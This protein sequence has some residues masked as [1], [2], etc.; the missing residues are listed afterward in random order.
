MFSFTRS[1]SQLRINIPGAGAAPKQFGSETLPL[2]FCTGIDYRRYLIS[3][4]PGNFL[5]ILGK[6]CGNS[7]EY[8]I[9]ATMAD[10][11]NVYKIRKDYQFKV[12]C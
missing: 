1:Q 5:L 2:I 10:Y 12:L 4:V 3:T 11:R 6:C 8:Y 7:V 9:L